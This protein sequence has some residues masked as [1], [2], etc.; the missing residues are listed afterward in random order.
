MSVVLG[1]SLEDVVDPRPPLHSVELRTKY[2]RLLAAVASRRGIMS[3]L[4]MVVMDV[5]D[6]FFPS[7][8]ENDNDSESDSDES[9]S[10]EESLS[11][12]PEVSARDARQWEDDAG[13]S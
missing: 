8:S 12:L 3:C 5:T 1:K 10:N 11:S 6:M 9:C 13:R 7:S 2:N 4:S